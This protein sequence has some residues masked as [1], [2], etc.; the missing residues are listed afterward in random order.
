[1]TFEER[2]KNFIDRHPYRTI[3]AD[4]TEWRFIL[5]G[6]IN[7][8]TLVFLNGGMNM[9]EMWMDYIDELSDEFQILIFDYSMDKRTCEDLAS[10]ILK[11]FKALNIK[12]PILI[13]ASFGGMLAQVIARKGNV[14]GLV[15]LATGGLDEG[16]IKLL[17]RKYFIAPLM[18]WYMKIC[19]YDKLKPKMIKTGVSH[20][21]HEPPEVQAYVESMFKVLFASYTKERDVHAT[22]LLCNLFKVSP[23]V[24][25]DFEYIRNKVLLML[26]EDDFFSP[27]MQDNLINL[28]GNPKTMS[29]EGGHLSTVLKMQDYADTIRKF[30]KNM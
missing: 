22:G 30:V 17:K 15:L 14:G 4:G 20:A 28:M 1:M 25:E 5:D 16:T 9:S 24:P 29:I 8:R 12:N 10:G 18:L 26:P 13:G 7:G 11:L 3:T 27:R 21:K 2:F 23:M 6:N 19:N